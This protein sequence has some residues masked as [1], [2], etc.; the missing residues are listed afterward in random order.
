MSD[1]LLVCTALT[2]V[3][4]S[5]VSFGGR[6]AQTA[7]SAAIFIIAIAAASSL[8]FLRRRRFTLTVALELCLFAIAAFLA[9]GT[10][11]EILKHYST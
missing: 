2:T 8:A 3:A 10:L 6:T 4:L 9:A 11:L 5:L 1:L 7:V